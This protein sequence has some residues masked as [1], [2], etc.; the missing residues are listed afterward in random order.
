MISKIEKNSHIVPEKERWTTTFSLDIE[1]KKIRP[2]QAPFG[3]RSGR[4]IA[5]TVS[6]FQLKMSIHS[7]GD[8]TGNELS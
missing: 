1:V 5:C 4:I 6:I 2:G 8:N 7:I 3:N